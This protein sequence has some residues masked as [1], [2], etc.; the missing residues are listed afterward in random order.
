MH[1]DANKKGLSRGRW[2]K[3]FLSEHHRLTGLDAAD[4][5]PGD[6]ITAYYTPDTTPAEGVREDMEKHGL[7]EV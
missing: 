1:P 3:A 7:D 5:S 4:F 6:T 2:Y